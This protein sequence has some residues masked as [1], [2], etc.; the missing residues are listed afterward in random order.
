META[1]VSSR[2]VDV[3]ERE[4]QKA[5]EGASRLEAEVK[6]LSHSLAD[7]HT[8][9]RCTTLDHAAVSIKVTVLHSLPLSAQMLSSHVVIRQTTALPD[10]WSDL[11]Q[12][13]CCCSSL[14]SADL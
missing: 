4:A 10:G 2:G 5:R 8:S 9:Y 7:L 3:A 1:S 12:P 11:Q 14:D 13:W 6:H